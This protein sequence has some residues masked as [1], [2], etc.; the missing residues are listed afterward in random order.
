M[1]TIEL[2]ALSEFVG[3]LVVIVFH[4]LLIMTFRQRSLKSAWI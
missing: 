1:T 3:A 2:D 4:Y